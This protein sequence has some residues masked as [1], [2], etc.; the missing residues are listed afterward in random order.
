VA[1]AVGSILLGAWQLR[2][3]AAVLYGTGRYGGA[4]ASQFDALYN[5][6]NML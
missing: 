2:P 4:V 6:V 1:C 3:R 5:S